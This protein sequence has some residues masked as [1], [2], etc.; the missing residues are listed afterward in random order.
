[1]AGKQQKNEGADVS[2]VLKSGDKVIG[3]MRCR[4]SKLSHS[5]RGRLFKVC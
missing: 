3:S 1:M 5:T 4:S 2:G